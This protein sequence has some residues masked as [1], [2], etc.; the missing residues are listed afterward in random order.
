MT[1]KG[2]FICERRGTPNGLPQRPILD[3][4]VS[5][6]AKYLTEAKASAWHHSYIFI[7]GD[8]MME[9]PK[10]RILSTRAAKDGWGEGWVI[11]Q[12]Y[13]FPPIFPTPAG[14]SWGLGYGQWHSTLW[15]EPLRAEATSDKRPSLQTTDVS[16]G[17]RST[18]RSGK[19]QWMVHVSGLQ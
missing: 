1:L 17:R 4:G 12:T 18:E 6:P 16:A 9:L 11:L 5:F 7:H 14:L 3:N 8:T 15:W 19:L 2:D 10:V 13:P